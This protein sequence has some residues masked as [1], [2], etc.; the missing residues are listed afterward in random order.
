MEIG[1]SYFLQLTSDAR[2]SEQPNTAGHRR[3][4]LIKIEVQIKQAKCILINQYI[5]EIIGS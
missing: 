1:T 4:I 3:Q 5:V 2:N